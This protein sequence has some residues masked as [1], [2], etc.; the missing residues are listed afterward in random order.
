VVVEVDV[1]DVE[2]RRGMEISN[3]VVENRPTVQRRRQIEM[4]RKERL[5]CKYI[6]IREERE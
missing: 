5:I 6:D 1:S 3:G 2:E 4:P